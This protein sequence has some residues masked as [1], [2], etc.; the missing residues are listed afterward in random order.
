[1]PTANNQ[2]NVLKDAEGQSLIVCAFPPPFKLK[3]NVPRGLAFHSN[4]S[5][6]WPIQNSDRNKKRGKKPNPGPFP[7]PKWMS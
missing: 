3:R 1:M 5:V 6:N 7:S 4:A 2:T